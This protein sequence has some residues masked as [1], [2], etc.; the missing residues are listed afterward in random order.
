M[1]RVYLRMM[2]SSMSSR[3]EDNISRHAE[4]QKQKSL[5][6]EAAF[7]RSLAGDDVVFYSGHARYGTGISFTPMNY[8]QWNE[9]LRDS[10]ALDRMVETLKRTPTPPK[11]LGIVACKSEAYYAEVLHRAAPRMGLIL[12]RETLQANDS[13]RTLDAALDSI[14]G[15][16][17]APAFRK[18]LNDSTHF[19]YY[20]PL[21]IKKRTYGDM[22]PEI[23]NFFEPVTKSFSFSPNLIKTEIVNTLEKDRQVMPE[24]RDNGAVVGPE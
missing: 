12:T 19:F 6:T 4:A 14:L 1:K 22:V 15:L 2:N 9:A 13:M 5:E 7:Q 24:G 16:K 20:N 10:P 11:L 23:Y 21:S 17:C 18:A 8:D 3:H